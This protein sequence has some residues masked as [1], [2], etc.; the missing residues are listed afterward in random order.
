MKKGTLKG[1]L[2]GMA[3]MAILVSVVGSAVATFGAK[4]LTV[5]YCNI[6][7]LVDGSKLNPTDVNGTPVEPFAYKGTTY[8]PARAVADAC[9]FN[10]EWDQ[11]NY[12]VK[13]TKRDASTYANEYKEIGVPA[14]ENVFPDAVYENTQY[15]DGEVIYTYDRSS[16][17]KDIL[18]IDGYEGWLE[19]NGYKLTS[20]ETDENGNTVYTFENKSNGMTVTVSSS[21][22]DTKL[23][24]TVYYGDSSTDLNTS[25]PS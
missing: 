23:F 24:V 18:L 25:E 15:L 13:L 3:V 11:D 8:L 1:F 22:D 14:M 17:P 7:I 19:D 6:Q 5:D 20:S 9:G 10:V 2:A 4:S 12:T 21:A 16:L